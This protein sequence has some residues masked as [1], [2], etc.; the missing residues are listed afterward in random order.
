MV[1]VCR[2]T[3]DDMAVDTSEAFRSEN[4][5]PEGPLDY[6]QNYPTM[7]PFL[8][9]DQESALQVRCAGMCSTRFLI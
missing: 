2:K 6:E 9:P 1:I 8:P 4:E 3:A 7:L 5:A